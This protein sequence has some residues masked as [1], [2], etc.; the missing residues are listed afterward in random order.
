MIHSLCGACSFQGLAPESGEKSRVADTGG[1]CSGTSSGTNHDKAGDGLSKAISVS[2]SGEFDSD[3]LPY[4]MNIHNFKELR[5]NL[6]DIVN[7][8]VEE[9]KKV[10]VVLER[11]EFILS[12]EKIED[13][14]EYQLSVDD[15]PNRTKLFLSSIK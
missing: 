11:K 1:A 2:F 5:D 13:N 14:G 7:I 10:L 9:N 6:V 12:L 4:T 3:P 8:T 15:K